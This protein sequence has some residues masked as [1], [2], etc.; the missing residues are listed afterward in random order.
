MARILRNTDIYVSEQRLSCDTAAVQL[1]LSVDTTDATTF[2]TDGWR[3]RLA[4][5][6]GFGIGIEG[7]LNLGPGGT[8]EYMAEIHGEP[9]Q[10]ITIAPVTGA[11]GNIAYFM[12][13]TTTNLSRSATLANPFGFSLQAESQNIAVR[14]TMLHVGTESGNHTGEDY[15]LGA[16]SATQRLY[17]G[18]HVFSGSGAFVVTIQSSADDT[19]AS[20]TTRL[21]FA[22]VL[23]GTA[24]SF[25]FASVAGPVTDTY[26]RMV[27]TNPVTRNFAVVAGII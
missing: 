25:E 14:G 21:T 8:E 9:N 23:T 17:A 16:V 24:A 27:A 6:K 19:F 4:G 12:R 7:Y 20:P 13:A 3:D 11:E 10:L 15:Q 5:L 26:W 22:T 18:L 1:E 2:C